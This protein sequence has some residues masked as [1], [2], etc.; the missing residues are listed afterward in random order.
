MPEVDIQRGAMRALRSLGFWVIRFG[1]SRKRGPSGTHSGEKGM[2]DVF[3]PGLGF[4]EFKASEKDK[5]EPDQILWHAKAA[6]A[7]INVEVVWTIE[8]AVNVALRWRGSQSRWR[9]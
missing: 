2:P 9:G 3:L 8:Q 6:K 5:L 1:V 7:G 4:L